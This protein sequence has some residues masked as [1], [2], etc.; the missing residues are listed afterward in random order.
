MVRLVFPKQIADTWEFAESVGCPHTETV[1]VLISLEAEEMLKSKLLQTT[2][3]T[4]S[5]EGQK[6][7]VSKKRVFGFFV[8]DSSF[9]LFYFVFCTVAWSFVTQAFSLHDCVCGVET[10]RVSLSKMKRGV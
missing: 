10:R 2:Y 7:R 9:A 8:F 6:V 5:A 4:V 3:F 1:G